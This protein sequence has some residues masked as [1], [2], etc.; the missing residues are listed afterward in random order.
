MQTLYANE[1]NNAKRNPS[2]LKENK[3]FT[4]EPITTK[5]KNGRDLMPT[6]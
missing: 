2:K 3:S 4:V 1:T 6:M 5:W